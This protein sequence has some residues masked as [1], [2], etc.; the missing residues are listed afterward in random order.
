M[1]DVIVVVVVM[2]DVVIE[3]RLPR[4]RHLSG[5]FIYHLVEPFSL[6]LLVVPVVVICGV[7]VVVVA[8]CLVSMSLI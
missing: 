6:A 3:G 7:R 1:F 2:L 8:N 5:K 4:A